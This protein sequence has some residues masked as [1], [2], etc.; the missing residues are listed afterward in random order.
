MARYKLVTQTRP[1]E[2]REAE[3]NEWFQ[4]VHMRQVVA[5]PGFRG[6]QRYRLA[7]SLDP[8]PPAP[9][10]AIYDIETTDIDAVL[11]GL[12]NASQRGLLTMCD[13]FLNEPQHRIAAIYEEF[14][15]PVCAG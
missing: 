14:G 7:R 12:L 3:Y 9:Y 15:E 8:S 6:A 10:L 4:N 13:A 2:G 1:V 11:G 5:L